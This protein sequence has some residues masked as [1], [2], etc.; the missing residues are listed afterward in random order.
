MEL[1]KFYIPDTI[2]SYEW[3]YFDLIS[4]ENDYSLVIILYNRFPFY[5][6]Y[7]KSYYNFK[8]GNLIKKITSKNFPAVS[9]CLYK[10]NKKIANLHYIFESRSLIINENVISY[11]DNV[12]FTRSDNNSYNLHFKLKY[13]YRR[14]NINADIRISNGFSTGKEKNIYSEPVKHFWKHN[15]I[16]YY[17][18][19][20]ISVISQNKLKQKISFSG[21]GYNDQNWGLNPIPA[22]IKNW[23]WGRFHKYDYTFIYLI[24]EGLSGNYNKYFGL[25]KGTDCLKE[26]SDFE[27]IKNESYNYFHL[28]Y[29][30]E[31]KIIND[32]FSLINT[33]RIKLDNGPFY[34]RF[35]AEYKI[36]YEN[37]NF[38]GRGISEYLYPPRLT[39]IF[40]KPFINLKIKNYPL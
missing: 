16:K 24:T 15:L 17:A 33:N 20:E 3:I 11:N 21:T 10:K 30:K 9:F 29:G 8:K 39:K 36:R 22:D 27:F 31:I 6:D 1:N 26:S 12:I 5:Y 18:S 25:Y 14:L 23:Y 35:L 4:E 7:I 40:F 38:E 32:S 19:A 37:L 2:G 28:K 13:P 34:I